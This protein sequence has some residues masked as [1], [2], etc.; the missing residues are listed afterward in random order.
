[1]S[2]LMTSPSSS[3][4]ASLWSRN[5]PKNDSWSVCDLLCSP[6]GPCTVFDLVK[7]WTQIITNVCCTPNTV[8]N[9]PYFT[10]L[11]PEQKTACIVSTN[12][13]EIYSTLV[14]GSVFFSLPSAQFNISDNLICIV[15]LQGGH[16]MHCTINLQCYVYCASDE[17]SYLASFPR[18]RRRLWRR[19]SCFVQMKLLRYAVVLK[20]R[21]LIKVLKTTVDR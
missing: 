21:I 12:G 6:F 15:P 3:A 17:M 13:L 2:S 19:F 11:L 9:F 14:K 10:V 5:Q 8:H 18:N 4:P 1:M 16:I 7:S 20:I